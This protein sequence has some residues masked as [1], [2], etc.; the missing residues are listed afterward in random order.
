MTL[1]GIVSLTDVFVC[2]MF[3]VQFKVSSSMFQVPGLMYFDRED[4]VNIK[5]DGF[6]VV[7]EKS[8]YRKGSS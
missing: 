3:R 4:G 5:V 2:L 7:D 8:Y 1:T 6:T